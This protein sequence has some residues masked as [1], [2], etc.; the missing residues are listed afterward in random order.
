MTKASSG[1][2]PLLTLDDLEV[3]GQRVLLRV[4]LNVSLVHRLAG[5]WRGVWATID[6]L[7][8]QFTHGRRS[9]VVDTGRRPKRA[10]MAG[11]AAFAE[12][13]RESSAASAARWFPG[14]GT[15]IAGRSGL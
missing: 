11:Q 13:R 8:P 3:E 2:G 5:C 15:P 4:D 9:T 6:F 12:A 10:V 7:A 1:R 14:S